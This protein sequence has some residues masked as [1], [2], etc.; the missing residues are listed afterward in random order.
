[1]SISYCCVVLILCVSCS[2]SD[3]DW[4]FYWISSSDKRPSVTDAILPSSM[5]VN[6]TYFSVLSNVTEF[7]C[8]QNT[9]F[10]TRSAGP[11]NK[12]KSRSTNKSTSNFEGNKQLNGRLNKKMVLWWW[13]RYLSRILTRMTPHFVQCTHLHP[14]RASRKR[15]EDVVWM[16]IIPFSIVQPAS[17]SLSLLNH[18]MCLFF[19]TRGYP[20]SQKNH[21]TSAT[22]EEGSPHVHLCWF[23]CSAPT[24]C[25][26]IGT[27]TEEIVWMNAIGRSIHEIGNKGRSKIWRC[28]QRWVIG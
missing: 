2:R 12:S 16:T 9:S 24:F 13:A 10:V 6:E 14:Q 18:S 5:L 25:Q 20:S 17:G 26:I 19:A 23:S 21:L 3:C 22:T 11:T 15:N 8:W 27:Q 1:M 4:C 7:V 28:L